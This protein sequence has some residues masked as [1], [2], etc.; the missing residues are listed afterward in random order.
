MAGKVSF[1]CHFGVSIGFMHAWVNAIASLESSLI[2][3]VGLFLGCARVFVSLLS[4]RV[5]NARADLISG[6]VILCICLVATLIWGAHNFVEIGLMLS[7]G[8]VFEGFAT[9]VRER[10][11][12]V[13][14]FIRR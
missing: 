9:W 8:Y 6:L 1:L 2:L 14:A 11:D 7:L 3:V 4:K 13:M 12:P 10:R 5:C